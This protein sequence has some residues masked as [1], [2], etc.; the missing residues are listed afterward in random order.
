MAV[1]A[2]GYVP[3]AYYVQWNAGVNDSDVIAFVNS[4]NGFTASISGSPAMLTITATEFGTTWTVATGA[5]LPANVP[6]GGA[7]PVFAGSQPVTTTQLK[8]FYA[9]ANAWP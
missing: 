6:V 4:C 9:P 2:T 1:A 3:L 8:A 7:A 5:Y